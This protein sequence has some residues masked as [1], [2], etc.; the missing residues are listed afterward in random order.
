MRSADTVILVLQGVARRTSCHWQIGSDIGIIYINIKYCIYRSSYIIDYD[1]CDLL[2]MILDTSTKLST[3]LGAVSSRGG[4][5]SVVLRITATTAAAVDD[6][7]LGCW[8]LAKVRN[9]GYMRAARPA[10]RPIAIRSS[11]K[12]RWLKMPHVS[13]SAS[14]YRA[15]PRGAPHHYH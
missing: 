8:K 14:V 15:R 5:S 2:L 12:D 4:P 1:L 9:V 13:A 6:L 3:E 11:V 10:S 7:L